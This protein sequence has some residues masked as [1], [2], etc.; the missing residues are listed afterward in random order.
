MTVT[1]VHSK[2]Y[3]T[4]NYDMFKFKHGNRPI[5][6]GHVRKLINSM[7]EVYIPRVI[8]INKNNEITDGQHRFAAAKELGL[9]IFYQYEQHKLEDIRRMNQNTKNWTLD[10]FMNSYVALETKDNTSVTGPYTI[11]KFFKKESK[12]PTAVC[13]MMLSDNRTSDTTA[14]KSGDFEIPSGQYSLALKQA[15]MIIEVSNYYDGYKRQKFI[16][17]LLG[18]FKDDEFRFKKFIRK[19]SLNRNKLYHCTSSTD[20]VDTIEKLYNWGEKTKVRFRRS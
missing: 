9:P 2:T 12:F 1:K 4:T 11:F 3:E 19:L 20:Y 10:D 8:S 7:R 6:M 16:V 18:L 15:K 13:L 14:F 5:D 17:A